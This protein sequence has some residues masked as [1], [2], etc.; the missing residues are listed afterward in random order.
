MDIQTKSKAKVGG[1]YDVVCLDRNGNVKWQ[2]SAPNLITNAGLDYLLDVALS[3]ATATTTWYLGLKGTGSPAAGDTMSSHAGW[4]E[5][6]PYSDA[7]RITWSEG[8]V[9]SQSITNSGSVAAFTINATSTVYG[10]FLTSDNTKSGT[11][12][13]LF[14]ATDFSSSRAV[15]SGDTLNVTYTVSAADDGA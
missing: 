10:I 8:G 4:S 5:I 3:G 13:T 11:S 14:S 6:T 2:E 1:H 15:E 9:S 12:G 7:N